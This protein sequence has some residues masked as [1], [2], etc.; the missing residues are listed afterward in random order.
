MFKAIIISGQW[1]LELHFLW[2]SLSDPVSIQP[3]AAAC[4]WLKSLCSKTCFQGLA[5]SLSGRAS[6]KAWVDPVSSG[7]F[8]ADMQW[9]SHPPPCYWRAFLVSNCGS[10]TLQ[11]S[12]G[13]F[14]HS[15]N[16]QFHNLFWSNNFPIVHPIFLKFINLWPKPVPWVIIKQLKWG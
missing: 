4:I 9:D 10:V 8:L 16:D 13:R 1:V 11:L 6:C 12:L 15:W 7:L 3:L 5:M 14:T 2:N